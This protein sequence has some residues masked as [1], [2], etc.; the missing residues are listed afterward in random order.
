MHCPSGRPVF[1]AEKRSYELAPGQIKWWLISN[2]AKTGVNYIKRFTLKRG[3]YDVQ[4]TYLI[5][6]ESGK[7]N[8]NP[9]AQLET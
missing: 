8:G 4:V 2:S 5:D 9:F 7:P 1:S 3:L 6:N